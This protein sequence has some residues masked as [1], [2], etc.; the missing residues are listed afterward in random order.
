MLTAVTGVKWCPMSAVHPA[1]V[2]S[3]SSNSISAAVQAQLDAQIK[4]PRQKRIQEG[5]LSASKPT[6]MP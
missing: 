6:T 3:S 5:T 4:K 1:T 2:R